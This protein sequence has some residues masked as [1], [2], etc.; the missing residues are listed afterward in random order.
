[1]KLARLILMNAMT[2]LV[3]L[4]TQTQQISILRFAA[5]FA[6]SNGEVLDLKRQGL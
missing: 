4:A 5:T 1:M 6:E 2:G 3:G